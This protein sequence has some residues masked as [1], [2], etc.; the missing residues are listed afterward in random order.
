MITSTTPATTQEVRVSTD[1]NNDEFSIDVASLSRPAGL[2]GRN[3]S[4]SSRP[5]TPPVN[6]QPRRE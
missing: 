1:G 2:V 4:Y 5:P 3:A 6:F